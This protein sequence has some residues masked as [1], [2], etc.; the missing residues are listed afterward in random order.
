MSFLEIIGLLTL[1][2]IGV[3]I[4]NIF[5]DALN[6]SK[7]ES[8]KAKEDIATFK[9]S[10]KIRCEE[11]VRIN[12]ERCEWERLNPELAEMERTKSQQ[13]VDSNNQFFENRRK[14]NELE[15][16]LLRK[17]SSL[18]IDARLDLER[19]LSELGDPKWRL[20]YESTKSGMEKKD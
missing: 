13:V 7:L 10:E 11:E 5:F 6:K 1:L 19:R 9:R 8:I 17:W 2:V 15:D 12:A 4:L 14:Q 20:L 18:D 16:E 3:V